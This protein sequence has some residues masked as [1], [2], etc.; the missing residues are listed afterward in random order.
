MRRLSKPL[1]AGGRGRGKSCEFVL[2]V[3]LSE[4]DKECTMKMETAL[5]AKLLQKSVQEAL[6]GPLL[7]HIYKPKVNGPMNVHVHATLE[8]NTPLD[9]TASAQSLERE[10]GMPVDIYI[11]VTQKAE[12]VGEVPAEGGGRFVSRVPAGAV[13][14]LT[15]V[16]I[17][18]FEHKGLPA[19]DSVMSTRL[20]AKWLRKPLKEALVAPFLDGL[21]GARP[22]ATPKL[23]IGN[24]RAIYVV[25]G[26]GGLGSD[27][28]IALEVPAVSLTV[29]GDAPV[30]LKIVLGEAMA[31]GGRVPVVMG[32]GG[33]SSPFAPRTNGEGED[34]TASNTSGEDRVTRRAAA[35]ADGPYPRLRWLRAYGGERLSKGPMATFHLHAGE[36]SIKAV[37]PKGA[38][39][40]PLEDVLLAPFLERLQGKGKGGFS[41]IDSTKLQSAR[42]EVDGQSVDLSRPAGSFVQ[43]PDEPVVIVYRMDGDDADADPGAAPSY[44][45][46]YGVEE[47]SAAVGLGDVALEGPL[48]TEAEPD[49]PFSPS[50]SSETSSNAVFTTTNNN[51]ALAR[52]R[53]ARLSKQGSS[54]SMGTPSRLEIESSGPAPEV[55]GVTQNGLIDFGT[56][57][58][59]P[60]PESE[61]P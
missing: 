37:L 47:P 16:T 27:D 22:K 43:N 41:V 50:L 31:V 14:T 13:F 9:V 57:M 19:P 40:K 49:S 35:A 26:P 21:N 1:I 28:P 36:V 30:D 39:A 34:D 18:G 45:S 3:D 4:T 15:I 5:G 55:S 56:P 2:H 12:A 38:L 42:I 54:G 10:D 29:E 53:A 44:A 20:N 24:V 7:D 33:G 32:E 6:L 52:A 11:V 17:D 25:G 58:G 46:N 48:F 51:R 8:D 61:V 59:T 23:V 60:T